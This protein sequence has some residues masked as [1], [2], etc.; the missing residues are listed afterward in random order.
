MPSF[1]QS[2]FLLLTSC[3]TLFAAEK[4]DG[5]AAVID[6]EIILQSELNAYTL[7]RLSGMGVSPDSTSNAQ[8]SSMF[9]NEL[10]DGKILFVHGKKDSTISVTEEEIDQATNN[11]I[12]M[13]LRQNNLTIDSLEAELQRQQGISLAKFKADSRKI[14]KE[15]L[16]KQKVQ[17]MYLY[18]IKV[19]KK[20]VE[21][22]YNEYKD[23]LPK[24]GESILLSKLSLK[25]APTESIR[26]QAF[27]KIKSIKERLDNGADFAE[28]AKNFSEGPEASEGGDLG[29]ISKGTLNELAFEE[30]AFSL[31]PGQFSEPFETRLGFHII[32]VTERK[33]QKVHLRQIFIK[34][35]PSADV[36]SAAS[37]RIDSIR[38][39]C[40]TS[41]DFI[42][43][44]KKFSDDPVSKAN[45]GQ[46][47][48]VSTLELPSEI[49]AAVDSLSIGSISAPVQTNQFITIYRID[50]KVSERMLTL[51]DDYSLLEKK[52]SDILSQKKLISLVAQWR[53]NIYIDIRI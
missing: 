17:Q 26:Q 19:A 30:K 24:M 1:R 20:D 28:L 22:F 4:I 35:E 39:A 15:Q 13:L 41:S 18:S 14:I 29:F 31:S 11:H 5:I 16:Y 38:T 10:I 32:N 7:M 9:L 27:Q 51:K 44:V 37:Q 40:K 50:N 53:K 2:F 49:K 21:N 6:D 43:A 48:W 42:N 33:D 52:T 47:H 12:T 45:Q 8:Y 3:S 46:L 34:I 23:S 36:I 25:L